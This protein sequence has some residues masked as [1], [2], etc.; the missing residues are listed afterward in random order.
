MSDLAKSVEQLVEA[1]KTS[2][3]YADYLQAR[4]TLSKDPE[5]YQRTNSFRSQCY[6]FQTSSETLT[7]IQD[8]TEMYNELVKD[9]EIEHFLLA[10]LALCRM[11][12]KINYRIIDEMDFELGF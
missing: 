4:D 10:E 1:I 2:E 5:K 7:G 3:E 9:S 12:Q 8:I 11:I 6:Q